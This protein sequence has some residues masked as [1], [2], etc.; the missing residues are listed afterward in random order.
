M[1]AS[2]RV[3]K[4]INPLSLTQNLKN[5]ISMS[6]GN[7]NNIKSNKNLDVSTNTKE[8][9]K[10][11]IVEKNCDEKFEINKN[12]NNTNILEDDFNIT[13]EIKKKISFEKNDNTNFNKT[14]EI[15]FLYYQ[16]VYNS[17]FQCVFC[18]S[19]ILCA[20]MQYEWEYS[21]NSN[22]QKYDSVINIA[23]CFCF[24]SSICLCIVFI[25]EH[26][27]ICRISFLRKNL[28]ERI[29]RKK[30]EQIFALILK[31]FLSFF[32]P[33][34]L[35]K[36]ININMYN[37]KYETAAMYSLN[38]IMTVFCLLRLW[39]IFKFYLIYSDYYSP[40]AYRVC[41]MN[42]F[43]TSLIFSMR[44]NMTKTPQNAYLILFVFI[45]SY[46]TYCLRIFERVLDDASGKNFSS[47]WNSLW[48]VFITMTTVG[49]GDYFPSSFLGRTIGIVSCTCGIFL[50]SMLIVAISNLLELSSIEENV[51][52]IMQRIKLTKEKDNIAAKLITKLAKVRNGNKKDLAKYKDCVSDEIL[53]DMYYFKEKE[54][55]ISDTFP[56]YCDNDKLLDEIAVLETSIEEVKNNYDSLERQLIEITNM[57]K[58]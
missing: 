50:I 42:N 11:K 56:H 5:N 28:P 34:P 55:E 38:S 23:N 14:K 29:W 52:K 44:A 36:G 35:L 25:Y 12:I 41:Q 54:K 17:F 7:I 18:V 20:I 21:T 47:M 26:F 9:G 51:F 57:L 13:H 3:R 48:C 45:L 58:N 8:T 33:N 49:Y 37:E 27:I 1:R 40:R 22:N 4:R 53:L 30:S 24:I 2:T 31:L 46:C 32:H 39:C 6:T 10:N 16:Y 19:S 15:E 43:D